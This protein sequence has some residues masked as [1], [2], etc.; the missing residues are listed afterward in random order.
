[1]GQHFKSRKYGKL[2]QILNP[3]FHIDPTVITVWL[4]H[5]MTLHLIIMSF[6]SNK[7][8]QIVLLDISKDLD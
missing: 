8:V 3:S 7:N 4:I 6:E 2:I 1:M 5:C